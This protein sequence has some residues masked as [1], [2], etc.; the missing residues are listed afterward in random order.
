MRRCSASAAVYPLALM[1]VVPGTVQGALV[2]STSFE[3]TAGYTVNQS[4]Q[5][6]AGDPPPGQGWT[7]A[8][9]GVNGVGG[10]LG[11][12]VAADGTAHD[13]T[14]FLFI[15]RQNKTCEFYRRFDNT[16]IQDGIMIV[17]MWVRMD[18]V[19]STPDYFLDDFRICL[20][21]GNGENT[22]VDFQKGGT[23]AVWE[24]GSAR[25]V[26]GAN[27][28]DNP[29]DQRLY[30]LHQWA[31][32]MLVVNVNT[33][34]TDLYVNGFWIDHYSVN[35]TIGAT[36]LNQLRLRARSLTTTW[37]PITNPTLP[38][39]DGVSVDDI[40]ILTGASEA[41]PGC[42]AIVS[43]P[44]TATATA[45]LDL[46]ATPATLPW[47]IQNNGTQVLNY[48]VTKT[49]AAGNPAV[50]DWLSFV[51][52]KSS[53]A[54]DPAGSDTVSLSII[55]TGLANGVHSAWL[56][57]DV[58]CLPVL[59]RIDLTIYGCRWS[60]VDATN[61]DVVNAA[62]SCDVARAYL[63]DY[64]AKPVPDVV[65]RVRND[66]PYPVGYTV[67]K[68]GAAADCWT[69]T[70]DTGTV[71]TAGYADVVATFN[72]AGL[73]TLTPGAS[74]DCDLLLSDTCSGQMITRTIR[75]RYLEAGATA[76]FAYDGRVSPTTN[77]SA[78]PG[79]TFQKST[80]ST[81]DG[82]VENDNDAIDGVTFRVNDTGADKVKYQLLNQASSSP[83]T[84]YREV[85]A[86][87]LG[88]VRV[89]A[90]TGSNDGGL[91]V[92]ETESLSSTAHWGGPDGLLVDNKHEAGGTVLLPETTDYVTLRVTV[93]GE[94][95]DDWACSRVITYYFDQ[96]DLP[97]GV[98]PQAAFTLVGPEDKGSDKMGF[99][100]GSGAGT[101]GTYDIAFDWLSGT[102]AGAFAPGEEV[103][104]L[105]K[106]LVPLACGSPFADTDGDGDVDQVDF[107]RFQACFT[108]STGPTGAFDKAECGCFDRPEPGYPNGNGYIDS[109]DMAEF[110]ACASGPGVPALKDCDDN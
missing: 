66:G 74:Y 68:S 7:A 86:T 56:R 25:L 35:H 3:T 72:P 84:I 107:A 20:E 32:V 47:T 23:L 70:N 54:I 21:S 61:P 51:D 1:L 98:E 79:W 55:T 78:G 97:E 50:Y 73:T 104:V 8:W 38:P 10:G 36:D 39:A 4:I 30:A 53:G 109:V 33:Q 11:P 99:G 26:P 90:Y 83:L 24:G 95:G 101:G 13:G 94:A 71:D 87:Y 64:P 29:L 57:F 93:V 41:P 45:D 96:E 69:L 46:P 63:Q 85:G 17:A 31:R 28:W 89:R 100:F 48:T 42:T 43:G 80:D 52:D 44:L 49:D 18:P 59:R 103:A 12:V 105:G 67:S 82:V 60:V 15:S 75:L 27:R 92:Y 62:D 88:R 65:H 40:Q 34:L 6:V 19:V 81:F 108:G 16:L 14:N 2:A 37:D 22:R 5:N 106:S 91:Y 110:E 76:T 58:G 77:D 9:V 102:N